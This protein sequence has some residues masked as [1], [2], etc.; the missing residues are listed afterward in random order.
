MPLDVDRCVLVD[1]HREAELRTRGF[2]PP[3]T[4]PVS[5]VR[6]WI[7]RGRRAELARLVFAETHAPS[8][9]SSEQLERAVASALRTGQLVLLAPPPPAVAVP[10]FDARAS[11][12]LAEV[13]WD[14]EAEPLDSTPPAPRVPAPDTWFEIEL[15]DELGEPLDGVELEL[16]TSE[17]ATMQVTNGAGRARVVGPA[18]GSRGS[19]IVAANASLIG[20][21]RERWDAVREVPRAQWIGGS[22]LP[23][24][25]D[26]DPMGASL[27]AESPVRLSVQPAVPVARLLGFHFDT[28]KA[29]LLPAAVRPLTQL[30]TLYDRVGASTLLIVGHTDRSGD[31]DYNARL[32]LERARSVEAFLRDDVDAWMAFYDAPRWEKRWGAAE[33]AAMLGSLVRRGLSTPSV[34]AYQAWHDALPPEHRAPNWSEL[35]IDGRIGPL[36]RRQLIG[37]YMNEDRTTLPDDVVVST[38]GAGEHYPLDELGAIDLA[39]P[40]GERDPHDR[41]VELFFFDPVLGVQP[42]VAPGAIAHAG[43]PEYPEWLRRKSE[44]LTIDLRPREIELR[45]MD[46]AGAPVR[47]R[48]ELIAHDLI[49]AEGEVDG[50]ATV[51]VTGPTELVVRVT[52]IDELALAPGRPAGGDVQATAEELDRG[53]AVAWSTRRLDVV[54]ELMNLELE[55][56]E[57]SLAEPEAT[58]VLTSADGAVHRETPLPPPIDLIRGVRFEG[59]PTLN[60]RYSLVI[61]RERGDR[62]VFRDETLASLFGIVEEASRDQ[63]GPRPSPAQE[64]AFV[65]DYNAAEAR[66]A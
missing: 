49:L 24:R 62:E 10:V 19:A 56:E 35:A 31:A 45:L 41:R 20:R 51:R 26:A 39:A 23:F 4:D 33:D 54:V 1:W 57:T 46:V 61:R 5:V 27:P 38:Y 9:L 47:G 17:G 37:D 2:R 32:G 25:G 59:L 29:F 11:D 63:V 44:E 66:Q 65:E 21:L 13:P 18:T 55:L 43:D 36:T 3:F 15:V 48:F 52:E 58:A 60:R 40:D 64:L 53:V 28:N 8:W 22:V 12:P 30:T 42:P 6:H 14:V 16:R 7:A 50:A 34:L